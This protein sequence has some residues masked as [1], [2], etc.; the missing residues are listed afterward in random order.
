ML[1]CIVCLTGIRHLTCDAYHHT[2]CNLSTWKEQ[3]NINITYR[4]LSVDVVIDQEIPTVN[5]LRSL[6]LP[7]ES[8]CQASDIDRDLSW[9]GTTYDVH[10]HGLFDPRLP[11]NRGGVDCTI[12]TVE[13]LDDYGDGW[14]GASISISSCDGTVYSQGITIST[15]NHG[16]WTPRGS[17]TKLDVCLPP[18]GGY[19]VTPSIGKH[20]SECSWNLL[21]ED[22]S[23][24]LSGGLDGTWSTVSTCVQL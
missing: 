2:P 21:A 4:Y 14:N 17:N 16:S 18:T 1:I 3:D 22:G 12:G 13:L 11:A 10:P 6:N 20:D 19:I 24:L 9:L 23:I 8:Q 5:L 7:A 15:G